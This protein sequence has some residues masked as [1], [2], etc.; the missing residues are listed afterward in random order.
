MWH[1]QF[2]KYSRV[3]K[4][5]ARKLYNEGKD[6]LFVPCNMRPDNSWGLGILENCEN[7]GNVG[8][9]FDELVEN[10]IWYNCNAETGRYVAFY[11]IREE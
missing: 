6:V 3:D 4:R 1:M 9:T 2:G 7:C 10:Y 5:V 8:W 11:K